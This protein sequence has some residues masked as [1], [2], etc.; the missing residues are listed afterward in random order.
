[1]DWLFFSSLYVSLFICM[2]IFYYISD[3]VIF[4]LFG[5]GLFCIPIQFLIFVWDAIIYVETVWYFQV[6]LFYTPLQRPD[7]LHTTPCLMCHEAFLSDYSQSCLNTKYSCIKHVWV[8]FSYFGRFFTL[9]CSQ[10]VSWML[11]GEKSPDF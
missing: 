2:S 9:M 6:L 7:T 5:T 11:K 10:I 4:N 8:L 1:M 3:I